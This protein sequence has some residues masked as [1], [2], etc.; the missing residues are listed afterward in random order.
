MNP[1]S[2]LTMPERSAALFVL[3]AALMGF[4]YVKGIEHEEARFEAY[5]VA[6]QKAID[7]QVVKANQTMANLKSDAQILEEVKNAEIKAIDGRLAV[8][9]GELRN[10]PE[11]RPDMP[12]AAASCAGATGADLSRPD[13]E[14]LE[15]YDA[16]ALKYQAQLK[17]CAVQY[18]KAL[19]AVN[20]P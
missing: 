8:A 15:R 12:Q 5:R 6:Q 7:A 10:R 2:L 3:A 20:G 14:F 18:E 1:M 4:G 19:K 9:L 13:A 11:R 17:Q 16:L